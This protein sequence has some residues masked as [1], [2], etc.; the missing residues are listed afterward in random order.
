MI[1]QAN[2]KYAHHLYRMLCAEPSQLGSDL[3]QVLNLVTP[4]NDGEKYLGTSW[5]IVFYDILRFFWLIMYIYNYVYKY[6][7]YVRRQQKNITRPTNHNPR[8]SAEVL[9]GSDF[10]STGVANAKTSES[11]RRSPEE[12]AGG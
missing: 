8:F 9:A 1:F 6:N 11:H 7:C 10:A 3:S 4:Q 12:P 2:W 5:L